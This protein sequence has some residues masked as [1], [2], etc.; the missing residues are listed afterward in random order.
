MLFSSR[1]AKLDDVTFQTYLR[2]WICKGDS[3]GRLAEHASLEVTEALLERPF[4]AGVL[5]C[6]LTKVRTPGA[7]DTAAEE[8]GAWL[9]SGLQVRV[10]AV[11]APSAATIGGLD[12]AGLDVINSETI[13]GRSPSAL[14]VGIHDVGVTRDEDDE[15][16]SVV[17]MTAFQVQDAATDIADPEPATE[18]SASEKS[19]GCASLSG[20][21][22]SQS[23]WK[24]LLAGLLITG[25]R[26]RQH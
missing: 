12:V 8:A 6:T 5:R 14:P 1:C 19:A 9:L 2:K 13:R 4:E 16:A 3:E 22:H 15:R 23:G 11:D 24:W 18:S 17:L 20:T 25:L 7:A 10:D 26:R 21:D